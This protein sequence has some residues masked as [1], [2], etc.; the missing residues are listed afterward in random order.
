MPHRLGRLDVACSLSGAL[1]WVE[2]RIS[3]SF[4]RNT[5]FGQ[6]SL[7]GKVLQPPVRPPPRQL[8]A[9]Y[10]GQDPSSKLFCSKLRGNNSTDG[11]QWAE[12]GLAAR[13]RCVC[14]TVCAICMAAYR[15]SN[16][17]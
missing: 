15:S 9:L 13:H 3:I 1:H 6:C 11:L 10:V 14:Q 16:N 8:E 7:H 2:E 5:R 4:K 17:L 12:N